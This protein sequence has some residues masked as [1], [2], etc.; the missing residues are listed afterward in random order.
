MQNKVM[1]VGGIV[2]AI[3]LAG[4]VGLMLRTRRGK[5]MLKNAGD[6]AEGIGD[7]LHRY[8]RKMR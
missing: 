1:R 2:A 3:S 6:F 8:M 7:D 4:A 5:K